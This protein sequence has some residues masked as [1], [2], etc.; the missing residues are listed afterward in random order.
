M[1]ELSC[2]GIVENCE[3]IDSA[4]SS[5]KQVWFKLGHVVVTLDSGIHTNSQYAMSI[6]LVGATQ[7][8]KITLEL[9]PRSAKELSE[10]IRT[11]LVRGAEMGIIE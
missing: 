10:V 9:S 1:K 7:D 6:D 3:A 11:A 8:A 2:T 4:A 5:G